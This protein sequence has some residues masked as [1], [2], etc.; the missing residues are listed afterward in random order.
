VLI[1]KIVS[2][3][4]EEMKNAILYYFVNGYAFRCSSI[5]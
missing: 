4:L 3:Y 1:L 2:A 5:L